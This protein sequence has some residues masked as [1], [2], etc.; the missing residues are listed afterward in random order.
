MSR[1]VLLT[2]L[3]IVVGFLA[4]AGLQNLV[5]PVVAQTNTSGSYNVVANDKAFVLYDAAQSNTWICFPTS[6]KNRHAWLPVK[7]LD[8]DAEVHNWQIL[9]NARE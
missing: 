7:R 5:Q 6:V 1:N 9:N 3:G 8:T 2:I 4:A